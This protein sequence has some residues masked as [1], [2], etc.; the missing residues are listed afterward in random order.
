MSNQDYIDIFFVAKH[1]ISTIHELEISMKES[2]FSAKKKDLKVPPLF[3]LQLKSPEV[4]MNHGA[5]MKAQK[6]F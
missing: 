6:S 4:V 2:F 1:V 3:L 5:T